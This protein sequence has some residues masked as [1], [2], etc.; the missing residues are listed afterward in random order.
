MKVLFTGYAPVH[1][2]CFRPIY[3]RLVAHN[4]VGVFVSGGERTGS[5]GEYVYD[6]PALYAQFGVPADRI[7]TVDAVQTSYFDVMFSANKRMIASTYNFGAT[8]QLFH[9]VSFRNRGVRPENLVYD[10]FFVTGPYMRRKFVETGLLHRNDARAISVG[11]PKTDRLL[12]ETGDRGDVTARLGFDGSRPMLLYA[13]TGEARNSLETVGEEVIRRLA[14]ADR[15]DL[16]I[17]P[18][19]HPKNSGIDWIERLSVLEGPHTRLAR[20]TDVVPLLAASDLLITDASSVANEYTLLDRPI[21]FLD[22]P[23][24]LANA[25]ANGSALDLETWGR[26]GGV[27]VPGADGIV[28]AVDEALANPGRLSK[29]RQAIANDLFYNP[30]HATDAA[31]AWIE[32]QFLSKKSAVG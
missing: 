2:V 23:E 15:Y 27:V 5:Q 30:G 24:L 32:A 1:F 26:K 20:E 21:V 18:H 4:D 31:M 8:I 3:D 9:G 11:F 7:L 14:E 17:K 29:V 16:L 22:V 12:T 25:R 10:H 6:G 19:D 28:E 13:P